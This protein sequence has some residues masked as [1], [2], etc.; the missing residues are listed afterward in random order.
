MPTFIKKK[1]RFDRDANSVADRDRAK[2]KAAELVKKYLSKPVGNRLQRSVKPAVTPSAVTQATT[3][4]S[5]PAAPEKPWSGLRAGAAQLEYFAR[6]NLDELVALQ[7]WALSL[8][9]TLLEAAD[10]GKLFLCLVWPARM[11]SLV[12]LHALASAERNFVTDLRGLRAILFPGTNSSRSILNGVLVNREQYSE[13]YRQLWDATSLSSKVCSYTKSDSFLAM[14][15]ALNDIRIRHPQ[16]PN[17]SFSE[18]IPTFIFDN[19]EKAWK[20]V[21]E[22]PLERSMRKVTNISHRRDLRKKVSA[23]WNSLREAP[24]SLMVVRPG[25]RKENWNRALGDKALRGQGKPELFLLDATTTPDVVRQKAISRIPEFLK[26]AQEHG[27]DKTGGVIVTDDPR[28]YFVLRARLSEA[29]L[30]AESKVW[31]AEAEQPLLSSNAL[32]ADWSPE[33]KSNTRFSV[34]IVDRDASSA[35]LVFYRL[36]QKLGNEDLPGHRELMAACFYILRL[37]NMPAG[38]TDLTEVTA[39]AGAVDFSSQR[40]TWTTVELDIVAAMARGAFGAERADV[41]SAVIR[42]RKLIDDWTDGTP[43][44]ARM[45]AEVRKYAV[46]STVGLSI[47]LPGQRYI[48]LAHRYLS[49]KLGAAWPAA[50]THVDFQVQGALRNSLGTRNANHHYV[51][52]GINPDV[53]RILLAHPAIPHGTAVLI[54]YKQAETALKTLTGMKGIAAFKPYRGRIG[55]LMQELEARLAE[56]PNPLRIERLGEMSLTFNLDETAGIDPTTE[57]HYYKYELEGGGCAYA[58]GWVYRYEADEDPFFKRAAASQIAPGDYVF[59][60]SDALHGKVEDAL[61]INSNGVAS[62]A[63][64][65]RTFLK[66]YHQDVQ[67]RCAALFVATRRTTLARAIRTKMVAI[68]SDANNCRLG[69]I[70]YWIQIKDG[71]TAP[72]APRDAKFFKL[73]CTAL[74]ISEKDTLTYWNFIKNARRLNQNLGRVLAAQYAEILFQPESAATYRK[75]P[76]ETIHHLQQEALNCVFR[77][78]QVIPPETTTA[79]KGAKHGCS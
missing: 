28:T 30:T 66:L 61:Q 50:E 7:P 46:A 71:E 69:R 78:E 11:P 26:Y 21:V 8:V 72:H 64:P 10:K 38:Y 18:I 65:Q 6:A 49:R 37:S 47:I 33:Q 51:F 42:A 76:L 45:L 48:Q 19:E 53:L 58:S 39:E 23:E 15:A 35:A 17:P 67:R 32:P 1:N 57:Q 54:A 55:L 16:L 27:Y 40:N 3:S 70:Y 74:E 68:D 2:D 77:V 44:A 14:L 22:A 62:S 56:V 43:M 36:A 73:F 79:V 29:G 60:M 75:I 59:E 63:L 41:N 20:T 4:S 52:V 5:P 9:D 24:G 31:A 13:L 25:S 12:M 34:S